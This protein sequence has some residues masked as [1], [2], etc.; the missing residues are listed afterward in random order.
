[1]D[2]NNDNPLAYLALRH[3]KFGATTYLYR[4][5]KVHSVDSENGKIIV[6]T[7]NNKTGELVFS[8]SLSQKDAEEKGLPFP[9]IQDL[10]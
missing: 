6:T 3:R 1:M 5:V 7:R 8:D 2:K 10:K 4:A 9:G